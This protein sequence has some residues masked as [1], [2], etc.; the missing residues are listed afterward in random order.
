MYLKI[1]FYLLSITLSFVEAPQIG[2]AAIVSLGEWKIRRIVLAPG[3]DHD[4]TRR[5][6]RR[7]VHLMAGE[8]GWY[9][10]A[11]D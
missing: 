9:L 3:H 10:V 5:T 8:I 4:H 2:V 6:D 7:H 1:F 11:S